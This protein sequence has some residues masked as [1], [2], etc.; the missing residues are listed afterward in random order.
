MGLK[1]ILIRNRKMLLLFKNIFEKILYHIPFGYSL[2]PVSATFLMT[3]DCNCR[4]KM[5]FYYNEKER[6]NT[7][8]KICKN[9]KLE[10]NKEEI[11]SILKQ[12]ADI[13]TEVIVIHGGEPF[14]KQNVFDIIETSKKLG[15]IVFI[16]T[17]GTLINKEISR[18]IVGMNVDSMMLSLDGPKT[19]HNKI[20]GFNA[21]DRL[22]EGIKNIQ[23]ERKRQKNVLP[24]LMFA[25]TISSEN[26]KH[27]ADVIEVANSV[28]ISQ[29]SFGLTTHYT[30]GSVTATK[31]ML[32]IKEQSIEPG[33]PI[34]EQEITNINV[35]ELL[36]EKRNVIERARKYNIRI[37]FPTD[38]MIKKYQYMS[39]NQKEYCVY[40]WR[41]LVISPYGLVYPC[42][43]FSFIGCEVG[44]L[45]KETLKNIINNK[46]FRD[47]RKKLKVYK[48]FPLCSK[49]CMINECEKYN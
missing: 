33:N 18:K 9:R 19:I 20:R 14:V 1:K 8:K 2:R 43:P 35:D 3:Y 17:N 30:K 15:L 39:Y 32:G 24:D 46:R 42:I 27:L 10:M 25:C 21:Y 13:G 28:G 16:T 44:N 31:N 40:P 22:I 38:E 45:R 34:L 37:W 11:D 6:K 41:S 29:V 4:C 49:C 36:S 48:K 5:C 12:I 26:Y 7:I 23:R 47:F